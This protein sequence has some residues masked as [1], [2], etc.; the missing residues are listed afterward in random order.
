MTDHLKILGN[1]ISAVHVPGRTR[2]VERF[3]AVVALHQRDHFRSS[4]AVIHQA[5]NTQSTLETE[6]DFGLHVGQFFLEQLGLSQRLAELFA[7]KTVLT[8]GV[9]TGFGGPHHAPGDAIA[10]TVQATKGTFQAFDVGQKGVFADFDFVENDLAGDA[11]TQGLF[12][13]DLGGRQ[14]LGV[15]VQNKAADFA[16]MGIGLGPNHKDVG[17]GRVGNPH[18][19]P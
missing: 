13:C 18:F 3:A 12:A 15:F 14:A 4:P 8:G 1:A 5:A 9:P 19:R 17:N 6:G 11:G 10:R 7:I 16:A 2:N